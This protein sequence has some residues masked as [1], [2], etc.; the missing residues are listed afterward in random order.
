[1]K[2]IIRLHQLS[3]SFE[4]DQQPTTVVKDISFEVFPNEIV[5]IVGE[6]GSG[7]SITS[8]TIMGLLPSNASVSGDFFLDDVSLKDNSEREW[9]KIRGHQMAM[10]FQEPMSSLNPSLTCGYQ[11]KEM[12]L[13]HQPIPEKEAKKRVIELFKQVKLPRASSLYKQYPHQL[14]GGQKQR[15]MIAMAIS[16]NPQLL[17]ADE[18]TTALDVTVQHSVIELLKDLQAQYRMSILFISHDLT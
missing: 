6:S 8:L 7:K 5:G 18:P 12:L 13:Q 17:I 16:N 11:V 1:M 15:V 3:V 4:T 10:I 2:P 14:S 9:K